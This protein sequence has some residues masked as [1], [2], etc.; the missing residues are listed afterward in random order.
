M[1]DYNVYIHPFY[2]LNVLC[3]F[4]ELVEE[5]R[6]LYVHFNSAK[7]GMSEFLTFLYDI[8][9]E[10][11]KLTRLETIFVAKEESSNIAVMF[12]VVTLIRIKRM[13]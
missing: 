3:Y 6:P 7:V 1:Q 11:Q 8:L 13:E 4:E 12:H 2:D 10:T 5:H 9:Q